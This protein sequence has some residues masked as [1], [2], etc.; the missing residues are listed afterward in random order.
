MPIL[1]EAD[2]AIYFPDVTLS[3]S[4]LVGACYAAQALAESNMGAN[5]P[6]EL[7]Q[8]TEVVS[9][10]NYSCQLSRFPIH[11]SQPPIISARCGGRRDGFGRVAPV[12]PFFPL[13]SSDYI[14]DAESGR[15]DLWG[16]TGGGGIT[17]LRITYTTGFDFS[18]DN[19]DVRAIKSALAALLCYQ[20][21][22]TFSGLQ[23]V[24]VEGEY[25][26]AYTG[27]ADPG[28]VPESLLI[29]FRKYKPRS[30]C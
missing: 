16:C 7:M 25:K 12:S 9:V 5:R 1:T 2:R 15:I 21:S 29:P 22:N 23:S 4:A 20:Q 26:V 10:A 30:F 3:E 19:S 11:E 8:H 18:Q 14:L 6:L 28:I 17:S 27:G 13:K 24:S